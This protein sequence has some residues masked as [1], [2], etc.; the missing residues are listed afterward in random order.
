MVIKN[1]E[2][3]LGYRGSPS[4][5]HRVPQIRVP[6]PGREVPVTSDFEN[7]CGVRLSETRRLLVPQEF[8][9][10]GPLMD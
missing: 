9:L 6:V 7:Q 4:E 8:L 10:K 1:H 5:E 3:Y 2:G